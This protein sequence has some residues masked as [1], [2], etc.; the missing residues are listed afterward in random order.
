MAFASPA[1]DYVERTRS[2]V[3]M[4]TTNESRILATSSG[5]AVIE[6]VSRL[7]QGQVINYG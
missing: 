5:F 2:P 6:P 4:F 3:T 7:V 1:N